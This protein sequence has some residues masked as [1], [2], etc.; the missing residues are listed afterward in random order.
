[1]K[2]RIGTKFGALAIFCICWLCV[3]C[4]CAEDSRRFT[5]TDI[6]GKTWTDL[7]I[8]RSGIGWIVFEKE[9]GRTVTM[10]GNY[11]YEEQ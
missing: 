8:A 3:G 10:R 4:E 11:S 5:A 9:D 6:N 1:M 2:K 7:K